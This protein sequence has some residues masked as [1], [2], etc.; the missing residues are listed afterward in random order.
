IRSLPALVVLTFRAGEVSPA[1]PLHAVVGSLRGDDTLSIELAP[2]SASAVASLA[3]DDDAE[4]VY[5]VT[6]G[7]PFYVTELLAGRA[8]SE[9][10]ASVANTVL[11]RVSR[12]DDD[13]RRLLELVSVVPGRVPTAL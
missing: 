9:L 1:H 6:G 13:E 7:N 12:L 3:G 8:T 10:P 4:S 11:G 5:T 2:L